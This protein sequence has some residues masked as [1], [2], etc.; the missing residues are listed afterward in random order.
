MQKAGVGLAFQASPCKRGTAARAKVQQTQ[1][2]SQRGAAAFLL[3]ALWKAFEPLIQRGGKI[4]SVLFTS[5]CLPQNSRHYQWFWGGGGTSMYHMH[6]H[7]CRSKPKGTKPAIVLPIFIKAIG[8]VNSGFSKVSIINSKLELNS[9]HPHLHSCIHKCCNRS[10]EQWEFMYVWV[11][12]DA[13]FWVGWGGS[14]G[15]LSFFFE[16]ICCLFV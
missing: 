9:N 13:G 10:M 14:L 5:N 2:T 15:V 1:P 8:T 7:C 16:C 11:C 12:V 6:R 3:R 4:H